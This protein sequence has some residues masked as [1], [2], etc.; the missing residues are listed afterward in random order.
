MLFHLYHR[1]LFR[2]RNS[3]TETGCDLPAVFSSKLGICPMFRRIR[4][5]NL[6]RHVILMFSVKH[7]ALS[8]LFLLK[9]IA[10]PQRDK[11]LIRLF[12]IHLAP[13]LDKCLL[14]RSRRIRPI[15]Y[16]MK[17]D[18]WILVCIILT[19]I[20][21]R[22]PI[23]LQ[24]L[25][26]FLC[27]INLILVRHLSIFIGLLLWNLCQSRFWMPIT[28]RLFIMVSVVDGLVNPAIISRM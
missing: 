22:L 28:K 18:S 10:V 25:I 16:P 21:A 7:I 4:P 12:C 24:T 14:S 13:R 20:H 27:R 1:R 19:S 8:G 3:G 17:M 5:N 2:F 23:L 15:I 9:S 26:F 11:C 6:D